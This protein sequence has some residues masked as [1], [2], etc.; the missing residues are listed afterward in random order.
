MVA[1]NGSSHGFN[2]ISLV[3]L[4][5]IQL[6]QLGESVVESDGDEFNSSGSNGDGEV[7]EHCKIMVE[8]NPGT[9]RFW[10]LMLSFCVGVSSPFHLSIFF[11]FEMLNT[12]HFSISKRCHVHAANACVLWETEDESAALISIE[13]EE[14]IKYS[15]SK[16]YFK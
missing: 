2:S 9:H 6:N 3:N 8:E 14:A 11:R 15:G 4:L 13:R 12:D 5:W 16:A 10:G 7:E 1:V